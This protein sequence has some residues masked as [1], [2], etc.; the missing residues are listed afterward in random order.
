MK[1]LLIYTDGAAKGNPGPAGVGI[2]F[3]DK[4]AKLISSFKKFI[5][6][7]TNNQAEY[8]ALVFAL[9][10]AQELKPKKIEVYMDSKLVVEQING[11]YKIKNKELKKTFWQIRDLIIELGGRVE[12]QYIPREKNKLADK[13][14]NQ[15]I[16]EQ[17][18]AHKQKSA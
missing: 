14:A 17:K 2:V 10:K 13:L 3:L 12:F 16:D 5:G 7:A 1:T 6:E 4:N 11:N 15:A 18:T 9:Q 8:R